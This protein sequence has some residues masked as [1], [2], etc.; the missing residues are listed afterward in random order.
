M[1]PVKCNC[2]IVHN[3][4]V[5]IVF[6]SILMFYKTSSYYWASVGG[7]GLIFFC[8]LNSIIYHRN[9][10]AD[11][12]DS[13][14]SYRLATVFYGIRNYFLKSPNF[15]NNSVTIYFSCHQNGGILM[16]NMLSPVETVTIWCQIIQSLKFAD[17]S[18]VKY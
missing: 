4:H 13:P 15:C 9:S 17:Y 11:Y 14:L 6:G 5:L 10:M 2:L 18:S 1:R 8:C 16:I 3:F 12:N 7:E